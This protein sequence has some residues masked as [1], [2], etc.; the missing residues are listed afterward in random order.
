METYNIK[1]DDNAILGD[2]IKRELPDVSKQE[3]E[4]V[5]CAL[6]TQYIKDGWVTEVLATEVAH[7]RANPDTYHKDADIEPAS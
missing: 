4:T 3:I 5:I 1:L 6:L 2:M 7:L